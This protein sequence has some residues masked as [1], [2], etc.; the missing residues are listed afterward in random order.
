MAVLVRASVVVFAIILSCVEAWSQTKG[1]FDV[2]ENGAFLLEQGGKLAEAKKRLREMIANSEKPLGKGWLLRDLLHVCT[3]AYDWECVGAALG[4]VG[5]VLKAEP[6]LKLIQP[7]FVYYEALLMRWFRRDAYLERLSRNGPSA[8][9]TPVPHTTRYAQLQLTL[10]DYHLQQLDGPAADKARSLALLGILM[11]KPEHTFAI[12]EAL[13]ALMESQLEGQDIAG[14]SELIVRVHEFLTRT[15]PVT[16]VTYARYIDLIGRVLSY[17]HLNSIAAQTLKQATHAWKASEVEPQVK[18]HRMVV[19]NSLAAAA[20]A[21]DGKFREAKDLFETNALWQEREEILV[22]ERFESFA[23]FYFGVAD[24]FISGV[25]TGKADIRWRPLFAQELQWTLSPLETL[26]A[27]SYRNFALGLIDVANGEEERGRGLLIASARQRL[28]NFDTVLK[29]SFEGFQLPSLVDKLIIMFGL[30]AA[31]QNGGPE[32]VDLMIKGSEVLGRNLRHRLADVAV[33]MAAQPNRR[34]R[35]N[36]HAYL[37]LAADKRSWEHSQLAL[38]TSK[39]GSPTRTGGGI[40]N[41]YSDA[42]WRLSQLKAK[43][44]SQQKGDVAGLPSLRSIQGALQPGEAYVGYFTFVGGWGRLCATRD[45]AAYATSEFDTAILTD[46]R[47][48]VQASADFPATADQ[49]RRYPVGAATRVWSFLFGGLDRCLTKGTHV[50]VSLPVEFSG[51]P[52]SALLVEEPPKSGEGYDLMRASWLVKDWTVS[53]TLSGRH[54]LAVKRS[55]GAHIAS[56]AFLGIGDPQIEEGEAKTLVASAHRRGILETKFGKLEFA[57]LPETADE[58]RAAA[59]VFGA[60]NDDILVGQIARE[61]AFRAKPLGEYDVIHFATHGLFTGDVNGLSD[62]ALVLTPGRATD[63][64]DDGLL[65]ASEV[66]RLSLNARL[67]I[68]SACNT[69][70]YDPMQASAGGQDLQAA[71]TIAGVPTLIGSLWAVDSLS[72]QSIV[73]RMLVEWRRPGSEGASE[74][75]ALSM[76]AF[77]ASADA[78]HSHPSY[79]AAFNVIGNG[80]VPGGAPLASTHAVVSGLA[81]LKEFASG[82]EILDAAPI[83]NDVVF[84]LIAEPDRE[85]M[86]GI[87]SRRTW[88]GRERWRVG[89]REIGIGPLI[90][91]E[92]FI[93]VAGYGIADRYAVIRAFGGDGRLRWQRSFE[94]LPGYIL[95]DIVAHGDRVFTVAMPTLASAGDAKDVLLLSLDTKGEDVQRTVIERQPD[96]GYG[97]RAVA[98]LWRGRLV[99]AVNAKSEMEVRFDKRH[100]T[101]L[102]SMCW[103]GVRATLYEFEPSNLALLN[104]RSMEGFR[105][106]ALAP[107]A[108]ELYAGGA[109]ADRCSF[110]SGIAAVWRFSSK[111]PASPVWQDDAFFSSSVRDIGVHGRRLI[112]AVDHKRKL[113]LE[114]AEQGTVVASDYMDKRWTEGGSETNEASFVV[115]NTQGKAEEHSYIGAGLSLFVKGLVSNE[116]MVLAYGNLGGMPAITPLESKQPLKREKRFKIIDWIGQIFGP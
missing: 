49:S 15:I 27:Q 26:D 12:S 113:S 4:E 54:F 45:T 108:D 52:L 2:Q 74:A 40:A 61:E 87:V 48:V 7:D 42:V 41:E 82:G 3:T 47:E 76:R 39:D 43:M 38:L 97:A 25:S 44:R 71:F 31:V 91:H 106:G 32:N 94:E 18:Q 73:E 14:A 105:V 72:T 33:L 64:Y 109:I 89:S 110:N 88:N 90:A 19:A 55:Q 102:P 36:A 99:V 63:S 69:A 115:L 93:Y 98:A 35:R 1:P 37:Q 85:R 28:E 62:G 50:T 96:R 75:L 59:A 17:S 58:I 20:L 79:W 100:L 56:R 60:D 84:A 9:A 81:P 92:G 70:R 6:K 29:S 51:I 111:G 8:F 103:K 104:G 10:T 5:P 83:G 86:N 67:V 112:L 78:T 30:S 22:S 101:G 21:L 11:A 57:T 65:T 53:V 80:T 116:D 24:L 114:K 95:S 46:V 68:L 107:M 34:A 23:A 66:A 13:V 16:S 77:L